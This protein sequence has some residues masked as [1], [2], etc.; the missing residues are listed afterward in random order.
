MDNILYKQ[1]KKEFLIPSFRDMLIRELGC[2]CGN[3]GKDNKET[4]IEYHHIV[5]LA[6]GGTNNLGNIVPLCRKCHLLVHGAK[7]VRKLNRDTPDKLG[8][9]PKFIPNENYREVLSRYLKGRLGK[10]ECQRLVGVKSKGTKLNDLQ[11]YID[12]LE[13]QGIVHMRN[14]VDA[15]KD[16][17][18][19]AERIVSYVVYNDG[20][21]IDYTKSGKEIKSIDMPTVVKYQGKKRKKRSRVHS[22]LN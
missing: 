12:Y 4:P 15:I 13:E 16:T 19:P 20:T 5:P 7:D 17:D 6:L 22:L 8:G 3:C 9:R 2:T 11:I 21:R 10:S 1:L 18:C 14:L